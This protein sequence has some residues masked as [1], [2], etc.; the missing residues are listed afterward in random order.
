MVRKVDLAVLA[1][2]CVIIFISMQQE[3]DLSLTPSWHMDIDS[4]SYVNGQGPDL[5]EK[6][7]VLFCVFSCLF[8]IPHFFFHSVS[9]FWFHE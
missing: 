6:L 4:S 7:Y 5:S 9:Y 8:F 2:S 1:V 3:G